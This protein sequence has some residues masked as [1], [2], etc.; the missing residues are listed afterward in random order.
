LGYHF[1][2][3]CVYSVVLCLA[4]ISSYILKEFYQISA[5][6]GLQVA[7]FFLAF[8]ITRLTHR[9]YL[10][11]LIT[12]S[13]RVLI[14]R[15]I[16]SVLIIS[17][18]SAVLAF[19]L[20][21]LIVPITD[22]LDIASFDWAGVGRL[23]ALCA[24]Y[25]VTAYFIAER[26][27][28]KMIKQGRYALAV[29]DLDATFESH[30][31]EISDEQNQQITELLTDLPDPKRMTLL[32]G[33]MEP[34]APMVTFKGSHNDQLWAALSKYGWTKSI[35]LKRNIKKQVSAGGSR[36][37]LSGWAVTPKGAQALASMHI[38]KQNQGLRLVNG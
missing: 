29:E 12:R 26:V 24:I 34:G 30:N 10:E 25:F 38:E 35:R 19:G 23:F 28:Q 2:F 17:G 36:K 33:A 6:F 21:L 27:A 7:A 1:R 32:K 31:P 18:V 14:D 9:S 4:L 13:G 20:D 3:I 8:Y 5:G 11:H 37:K 22:Y 16:L 15:L